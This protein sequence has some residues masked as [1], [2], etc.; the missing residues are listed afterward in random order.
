MSKATKP[1]RMSLKAPRSKRAMNP[2][3]TLRASTEPDRRKKTSKQACR[4][5]VGMDE[6]EL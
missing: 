5:Q 1:K 2:L 4:G 3:V 6:I